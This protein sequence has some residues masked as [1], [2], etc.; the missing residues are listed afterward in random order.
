MP[1]LT[2]SW[3]P[4]NFLS[5]T[6]STTPDTASE[7]QEAEAPPVT[8]STRCKSICGNWL[9]SITPCGEV[10]TTRSPSI[11]IRL[12]WVPTPRRFRV[13]RPFTPLEEPPLPTLEP[14]EP[15]IEGSWVIVV[16]TL[17]LACFRMSSAPITV[18]GVGASNPLV[19]MRVEETVTCSTFCACCCAI[20]GA[21][22]TMA[23][24][25]VLLD[26]ARRRLTQP[27][28][29]SKGMNFSLYRFVSIMRLVLR[30]KLTWNSEYR[31]SVTEYRARSE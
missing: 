8:T 15:I 12:R 4:S 14:V 5:R 17:E 11:R 6:K 3:K 24:T 26:N 20:A 22:I 2:L 10:G 13:E 21:A 1:P 31:N 27:A 28:F 18:V 7:P 16:K 23:R 19:V 29:E 30:L 25:A 9:M